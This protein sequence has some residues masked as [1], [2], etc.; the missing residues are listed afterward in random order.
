MHGWGRR[1]VEAAGTKPVVYVPSRSPVAELKTP[2]C[3]GSVMP[4]RAADVRRQRL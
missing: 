2:N 3:K 4:L 1:R